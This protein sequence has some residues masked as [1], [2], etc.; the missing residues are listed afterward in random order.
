MSDNWGYVLAGYTITT[1][2]L[3]TYAA[4]LRIRLRR[5]RQT[6]PGDDPA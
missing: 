6:L 4:W 2:T 3:A 1:A 5:V